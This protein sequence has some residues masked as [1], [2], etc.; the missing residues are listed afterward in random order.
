LWGYT[1]E[2]DPKEMAQKIEA[3]ADHGIDAFIFDWYYYDDGPFLERAL[4]QGFFG[5][6]NRHRLRFALMW[7]NH[8]W[9]DIFPLTRTDL[10]KGPKLL[11]PGTVSPSTWERMTGDIITTYFEHPSYWLIDGKPYFSIYDLTRFIAIFGG[12]EE[13]A[14]AI[15]DLREKVRAAGFPGLNLNAVVWG[16]T[17]L[18]GGRAVD[19]VTELIETLGF[20]SFTSYVWIHHLPLLQFPQ[21]PY[22]AVQREYFAYAEAARQSSRLPYYPN[23]TMGWD[24][25]PRTHQEDPFEPLG[26]PFMATLSGNT[27]QAFEGALIQMK[28]FLDDEERGHRIFNINCWNEWT[29][30][31]YLEPDTTNGMA[32]LEAIR[33]VFGSDERPGE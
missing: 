22:Q 27:P 23:V 1:D 28:A 4:E 33:D 13:T 16:Q 17:I 25:S 31:S 32:Y 30:G 9:M 6:P 7:A 14:Q 20:D 26:Y 21:T 11:Y 8:D 18:P 10:Q 2:S 24:S 12:A 3:A 29:E 19:D 5:A 15:S